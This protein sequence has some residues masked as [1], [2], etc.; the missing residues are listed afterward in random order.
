M[1]NKSDLN[2]LIWNWSYYERGYYD[3]NCLTFAITQ[4]TGTTW[5]WSWGEQKSY[6]STS[7]LRTLGFNTFYAKDSCGTRQGWHIYAYAD[8]SRLI[9]HFATSTVNYNGLIN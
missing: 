9:S 1:D 2:R 5:C 8:E 7:I 3:V 6:R 4:G